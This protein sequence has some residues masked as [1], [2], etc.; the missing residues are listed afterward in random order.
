MKMKF[1][2]KCR[3]CLHDSQGHFNPE[4][5]SFLVPRPLEGLLYLPLPSQR[6]IS[7]DLLEPRPQ[8][9]VL[10]ISYLVYY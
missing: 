3:V 1:K 2:M 4:I 8:T 9:L 5:Q 7:L 10:I 6:V